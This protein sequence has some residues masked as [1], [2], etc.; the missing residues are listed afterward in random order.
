M[1]TLPKDKE[2]KLLFSL[3]AFLSG[4]D[5]TQKMDKDQHKTLLMELST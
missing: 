5:L 3:F 4:E 1:K 2:I